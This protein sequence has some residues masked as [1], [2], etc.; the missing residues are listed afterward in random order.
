MASSLPD[1][2]DPVPPAGPNPVVLALKAVLTPLASLRLT[3]VLLALAVGL[4]F[5][6]TLAQKTAGMWTVIDKYFWSWLVM[7]DLQP[8]LEFF[9]IFFGASK[10]ATAP[11]S[12]RIPYPGGI[13]IGALMF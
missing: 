3:V 11:S 7:I 1:P 5:L 8:T 13:T 6:G 12:L 9:K 10:D 4:I 2:H